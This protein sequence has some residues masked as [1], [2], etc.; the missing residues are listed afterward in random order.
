MISV[1]IKTKIFDAFFR[2]VLEPIHRLVSVGRGERIPV[3]RVRY[4]YNGG[5]YD[6]YYNCTITKTDSD[7]YVMEFDDCEFYVLVP[8]DSTDEIYDFLHSRYQ[9]NGTVK[10]FYKSYEFVRIRIA[11]SLLL[12]GDTEFIF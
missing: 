8:V 7:H 10:S 4:D 11:G 12:T 9:F 3:V 1:I 2:S 6:S 5:S